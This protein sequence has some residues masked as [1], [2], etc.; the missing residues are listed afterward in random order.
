MNIKERI[1]GAI[2]GLACGDALGAPVEFMGQSDIVARYG[3]QGITELGTSYG[4]EGA[5]TDDTQMSLATA[6]GVLKAR[7]QDAA[8]QGRGAVDPTPYIYAEYV[9]WMVTQTVD[10]GARRAAGGTCTA[11]LLSGT[12]GHWAAPLNNSKGCGGVMRVAPIGLV[13]PRHKAWSYGRASAAL[14]H[15]HEG[16]FLPAGVLAVMLCHILSK[17][18]APIYSGAAAPV[19]PDAL[20]VG[21]AVMEKFSKASQY[22]DSLV[23]RL[24]EAQERAQRFE[25]IG[26]SDEANMRRLGAGWAGDEALAMAYYCAL[27][28]PEDP[29]KAIQSAV[30]LSGDRDS[31]GSI[32][33][34]LMGALCGVE[35]I[36]SSWREKVENRSKLEKVADELHRVTLLP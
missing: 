15:G 20:T 35:A 19:L 26:W 17:A 32:C 27:R 21:L 18:D 34:A 14:T 23:M 12:A 24:K 5:Y 33:G 29:R 11:A 31:V 22:R 16:G 28:W 3:P 1:R 6:L 9:T 13:Y 30:H 10:E 25:G 36:P 2:I 4:V 7:A 8:Y